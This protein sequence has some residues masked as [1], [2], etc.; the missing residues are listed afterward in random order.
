MN[1]M[2]KHV[3]HSTLKENRANQSQWFKCLQDCDAMPQTFKSGSRRFVWSQSTET[4]GSFA[5]KDCM[6]SDATAAVDMLCDIEPGVLYD[7]REE[8]EHKV[9]CSFCTNEGREY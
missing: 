3:L 5:D 9:N 6:V 1:D 4:T 7:K 8:N 2:K